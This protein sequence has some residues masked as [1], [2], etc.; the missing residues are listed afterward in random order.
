[1]TTKNPREAEEG[2]I[3]F[4]QYNPPGEVEYVL[5]SGKIIGDQESPQ[6]MIERVTTTLF[7]PEEQF[8][9]PPKE[10][11]RMT[12][13]FA[14]YMV[15]GY[16]MPGTPTLTNAGRY[17]NALSSC[18]VIPVDLRE[19]S[20]RGKITHYYRQNMGSGFDFTPYDDPVSL[21]MWINSLYA[22]ETATEQYDRYIGNMGTLHVSHPHIEQFIR[23]KSEHVMPHFNISVDVSEAFM[24]A[25]LA[26]TPF[27]LADGTEVD[28]D[29][30]LTTTAENAW[31][32]GDPGIIYMERMNRD[33]PLAN[34]SPYVSTP[35]CSEM[36]LSAGETCQFGYLNLARFVRPG[37]NG[38]AEMD[39]AKLADATCLMTRV[40][41]NAVEYSISRY[42]DPIS[43]DVARLKR[44]IGIGVCGLSDMF[45]RYN[46][47]YDSDEARVIARDVLSFI[48]YTS[49]QASVELAQHRGPCEAM[50]MVF[51]NTFRDGRYL[52]EKFGV[53]PTNTISS[54]EWEELGAY[55]RASGNLRNILTTSLPPTGRA[56]L[57][58]SASAS[59]EPF[60]Q[61]VS[62]SGEITGTIRSFLERE[63]DDN[64][65]LVD[66]VIQE[67]KATGSFQDIPE[68]SGHTR[69]CLQTATEI[70]PGEH[71]KM[72]AALA[73]M[74]GV[75]DEAASKTINLPEYATVAQVREI[76][77]Q[78]YQLGIKN[79]SVYRDRSKE[80]QPEKL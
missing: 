14:Q 60:F 28:A 2:M 58:L 13:E 71:L 56:S 3:R 59:V 51:G 33:N 54:K 55:I 24:E 65:T 47:P 26:G 46:M 19:Q 4:A 45:L 41:D 79:I 25:A 16:L 34:I 78:S 1:M 70:S 42:P 61:V 5:R 35:P 48:N 57:L 73:G 38:E 68:L 50:H 23:A 62:T 64:K 49:K 43:A 63:F 21:L 29:V 22:E 9:T 77:V 7:S 72:V 74:R 75:V 6:Q 10:T 27:V 76:Y 40:L 8:G 30:L 18:V 20:A 12:E 15:D 66:Q 52:E 36:G 53:S 37:G 39:Y 17:E 69:R 11:Q 32:T 67:A 80:G 44:K 31:L